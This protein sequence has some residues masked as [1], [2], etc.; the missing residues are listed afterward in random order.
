[1]P[2]YSRESGEKGK[3]ITKL[4]SGTFLLIGGLVAFF[5]IQSFVGELNTTNWTGAEVTLITTILPAAVAIAAPLAIY[6][7]I[8][9]ATRGR[10]PPEL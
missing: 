7:G 5:V 3:A 1:M 2:V 4:F 8:K 6:M 9:K 10:H